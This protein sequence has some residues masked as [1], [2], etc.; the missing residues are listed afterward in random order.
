MVLCNC[1]NQAVVSVVRGGYSRVPPM[2]HTLWCLFFVE[3]YFDLTIT[4]THVPGAQNGLA[5]CLSRKKMDEFYVLLPHAQS[6]PTT[7]P[8]GLVCLLVLPREDKLVTC[9][10]WRDWLESWATAP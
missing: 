10:D 7:V 3:A 6:R 9:S 1:D 5:D 2:A 8:P 4:T